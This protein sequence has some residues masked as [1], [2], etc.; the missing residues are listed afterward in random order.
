M[1]YIGHPVL[2]DVAYGGSA[3]L[4]DIKCTRQM[5]HSYRVKFTHPVTSK[6]VELI[7]PLP[8]DMKQ[9]FKDVKL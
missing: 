6:S 5:L 7:A 2:G 4:K 1:K 9:L 3:H 8:E